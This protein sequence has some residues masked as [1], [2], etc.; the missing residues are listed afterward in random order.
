MK[1]EPNTNETVFLINGAYGIYVPQKFAESAASGF[2]LGNEVCRMEG[3]SEE[4]LAVLRE[5]PDNACY[6][7]TWSQVIDNAKFIGLHSGTVWQLWQEDDLFAY[8]GD[9]EQWT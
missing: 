2:V 3:V 4:N 8:T 6:E 1:T 5:G 7:E 9:G